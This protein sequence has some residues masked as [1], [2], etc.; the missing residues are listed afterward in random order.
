MIPEKE[1]TPQ[2]IFGV[3]DKIQKESTTWLRGHQKS[4]GLLTECLSSKSRT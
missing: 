2:H 1:I 4:S 3:K